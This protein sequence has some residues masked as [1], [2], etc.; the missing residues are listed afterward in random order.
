LYI[1]SKKTKS[2]LEKRSAILRN[3]K[4]AKGAKK[5]CKI[6]FKERHLQPP[7]ASFAFIFLRIVLG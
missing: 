3:A 7:L 4:G 2:S 1:L 6:F 5:E